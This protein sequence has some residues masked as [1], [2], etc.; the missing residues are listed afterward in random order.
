MSSMNKTKAKSK[1]A[2][3]RNKISL[4]GGQSAESPRTMGQRPKVED[5]RKVALTARIRVRGAKDL[6]DAK[7][8]LW[9]TDLGACIMAI[10]PSAD[11]KS[12][13][14]ALYSM[15]ASRRT[16]T[17]RIL[18]QT[19]DPKGSAL[20]MVPDPME[21]DQGHTIDIRSPEER[22]IAARR[23]WAAWDAKINALPAPQMK[24][25]LRD[26]LMGGMNGLGGAV[27]TDGAPTARGKVLVMA[28]AIL[29]KG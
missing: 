9:E 5:P 2:R 4:A 10:I 19:G 8:P 17:T 21:T 18:G 12:V 27:L 14:Q 1:A 22:D 20:A 7:D 26:A 29:A 24:W 28:I 23:N 13:A 11:R 25:F 16:F 6:E 15:A 3:R